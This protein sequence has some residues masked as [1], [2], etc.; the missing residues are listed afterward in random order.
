MDFVIP[1]NNKTTSPSLA[2]ITM[3]KNEAHCIRETLREAF[4]NI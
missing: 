1:K 4:I 2:F 3:C